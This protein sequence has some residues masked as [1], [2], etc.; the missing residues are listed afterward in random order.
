M[1]LEHG[2]PDLNRGWLDH[3]MFLDGKNRIYFVLGHYQPEDRIISILKYVP[4]KEG[5]WNQK[6][7]G[8]QYRRS[9]WHQGIEAFNRSREFLNLDS[10]KDVNRWFT[11]D[12]VFHTK[13]LEFPVDKIKNYMRPEKRLEKI[14][15]T[16]ENLLDDLEK[17]VKYLA[18]TLNSLKLRTPLPLNKIGITGSILWGGHSARSDINLNIYGRDLCNNLFNTLMDIASES[19]EIAPGIHLYLKSFEDIKEISRGRN[20]KKEF[21]KRKP[22]IILNGFSPGIQ[23]RFCLEKD[24]FPIR[25]GEEIYKEVGSEQHIVEIINDSYSIFYPSLLYVKTADNGI[26]I[27]KM[28]VYDTRFTRLF[29]KG[30]IV[31]I[32]GLVQQINDENRYQYLLGAKNPAIQEKITF[33]EP[34]PS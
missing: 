9:Y 22:K 12:P 14:Y 10:Q 25:Y 13:F 6:Q 2:V 23:I 1:F 34:A 26:N 18:T 24:E 15:T 7:T 3:D 16:K 30:D 17:K 19:A 29:K 4:E 8:I 20:I 21:L 11:L 27:E 32:N 31:Q 33:L 5:T 28:M